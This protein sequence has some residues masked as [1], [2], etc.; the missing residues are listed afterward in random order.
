M[1]HPSRLSAEAID[2]LGT[3]LAVRRAR[4]FLLL[5]E[6]HL[7]GLWF[8]LSL[9]PTLFGGAILAAGLVKHKGDGGA[10]GGGLAILG[11]FG[12]LAFFG[13]KIM[14]RAWRGL[15]VRLLV[16]PEGIIY[17]RWLRIVAY[18]WEDIGAF[19]YWTRDQMRPDKHHPDKVSYPSSMYY[20]RFYHDHGHHFLFS[21][22]LDHNKDKPIARFVEEG[23]LDRQLP[24]LRD[25]LLQGSEEIHF[26]PFAVGLEGLSS[27]RTSLPW[28][29]IDFI[30]LEDGKVQVRKKGKVFNWCSVEADKVPNCC[31]FLALAKERVRAREVASTKAAARK[32]L[33]PMEEEIIR[34]F[35][36]KYLGFKLFGFRWQYVLVYLMVFVFGCFAVLAWWSGSLDFNELVLFTL[37]APLLVLARVFTAIIRLR[38]REELILGKD[39]LRC[40]TTKGQTLI[41][42]PYKNIA[43]LELVSKPGQEPYIGIDLQDPNDPSTFHAGDESAKNKFGWH[44]R[45]TDEWSMPVPQIYERLRKRLPPV[46]EVRT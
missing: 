13:I 40:A 20:Y 32:C 35:D 27:K 3:P 22:K 33:D 4:N 19:S 34:G 25:R 17:T 30:S 18:R 41:Q 39:C 42:I 9:V 46:L 23:L 36:I 26:G 14:L 11:F 44:Y 15:G 5:M 16:F 12:F 7:G 37:A 45:I 28:S 24:L 2:Q 1:D 31:L 10:L 29:E 43:V 6:L 38:R 21:E 8:L